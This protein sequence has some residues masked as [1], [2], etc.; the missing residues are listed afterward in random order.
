MQSSRLFT[1]LVLLFSTISLT[2]QDLTPADLL[3]RSINY[4]D[5]KGKWGKIPLSLQLRET[6]PGG[7]DRMTTV[8]IDPKKGQF[9]LDQNRNGD[10]IGILIKND[11]CVFTLN[12]SNDISEADREKLRLNCDRAKSMRNY[13]TY[14]WGLPMKLQDEGTMLGEVKRTTFMER[15]AYSLKVMYDPEVGSD[16]WYF[17]FDPS[18]YALIGYRF[19][20]DEAANDGE[21]ITLEGEAQL[22]DFRLP[23]QRKWY[24]HKEDKFLGEDILE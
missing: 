17:Y 23:K 9:E 11:D 22:K 12:G 18:T 19:Y 3:K 7:P 1:F 6:R 5:P 13:Y 20:H 4:H 24:T 21:Y 8:A 16:I 10:Q 2:A 15:D 14:L